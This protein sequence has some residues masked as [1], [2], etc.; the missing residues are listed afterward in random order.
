MGLKVERREVVAMME[1]M[2]TGIGGDASA[3]GDGR[4]SLHEFKAAFKKFLISFL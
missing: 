1:Q 3:K 2:D 4:L